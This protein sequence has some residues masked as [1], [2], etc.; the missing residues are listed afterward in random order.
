MIYCYLL[1]ILTYLKSIPDPETTYKGTDDEFSLRVYYQLLSHI[2]ALPDNTEWN[3]YNR[4]EE[5]PSTVVRVAP[6][7]KTFKDLIIAEAEKISE[8]RKHFPR[9]NPE[10]KFVIGKEVIRRHATELIKTM[11]GLLEYESCIIIIHIIIITI[12][13][14][15]IIY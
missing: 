10:K 14:L 12:I 13:T 6:I 3:G 9:P 11:E 1:V 8:H 15:I 7:G 2:K 4:Y 5:Y